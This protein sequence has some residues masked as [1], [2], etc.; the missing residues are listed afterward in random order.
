MTGSV[1]CNEV[2]VN[3]RL[4]AGAD[5]FRQISANFCSLSANYPAWIYPTADA[6]GLGTWME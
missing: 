1:T 5:H 2:L 6:M 3:S 4:D